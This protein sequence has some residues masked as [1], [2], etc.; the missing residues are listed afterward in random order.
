[1]LPDRERFC[2][3]IGVCGAFVYFFFAPVIVSVYCAVISAS[4]AEA[5]RN[6]PKKTYQNFIYGSDNSFAKCQ[7]TNR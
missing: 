7:K 4:S 5:R 3:S 2:F 1:M 6:Y